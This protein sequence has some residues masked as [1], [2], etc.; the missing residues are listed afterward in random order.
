VIVDHGES[1]F[2]VSG[3]LAHIGVEVGQEV[4]EGAA[5]GTVGESGSLVGPRLY[6]EIRRG[7]EA[8]DPA[9]WFAR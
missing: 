8:L 7:E 5:I 1:Y 9:D 4:A 6:F 2:T 3:H